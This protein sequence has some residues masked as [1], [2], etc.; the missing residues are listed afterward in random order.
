MVK[1]PRA[2]F[3]S[4]SPPHPRL[5]FLLQQIDGDRLGVAVRGQAKLSRGFFGQGEIV[6]EEVGAAVLWLFHCWP[7]KK[8]AGGGGGGY[9][10]TILLLY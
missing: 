3:P 6:G 2:P 1:V 7:C 4:H 8:T 5:T 10:M 9:V